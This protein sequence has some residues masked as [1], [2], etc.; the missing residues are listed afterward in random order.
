MSSFVAVPISHCVCV[1]HAPLVCARV[2]WDE[3]GCNGSMLSWAGCVLRW[4]EVG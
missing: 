1:N 4:D 2:G 3:L